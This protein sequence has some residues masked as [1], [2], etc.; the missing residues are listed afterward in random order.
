[1]SN[2][3]LVAALAC[4]AGGSRLYGKPLQHID[5]EFR[6]TILDHIL[7]T[8]KADAVIDEIVLGIAEGEANTPFVAVAERWGL[9][10]IRGDEVDVLHR[11]IQCAHAAGGTD[12]FRITTECPFPQTGA[13]LE[14]AWRL[15]IAHH[16]DVTATD[17]IPEGTHFEI[18][19]L[20][21]LQTSHDNGG[22]NER[23]EG[24]A[25]Y[26]R[27]HMQ[28]FQI[29]VAEVPTAWERHDLRLT[30]DYPEDLVLC[31]RV[32][33][34]VRHYG[35]Q[36]PLD[37]IIAFLDSRPDLKEMVTPYVVSR[38]LWAGTDA[39]SRA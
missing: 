3:R 38:R 20:S 6:V 33:A 39:P 19:R 23:S 22:A 14:R 26:I 28:D 27:A 25:R 4:R 12:V 30:V 13:I 10:H 21:A 1:M 37:P 34:A 7:Q 35:P 32:Y 15:H 2:R 5:P 8:L 9:R 29:E 24:C 11:L 36:I 16:N 18:F 31:R 17:G